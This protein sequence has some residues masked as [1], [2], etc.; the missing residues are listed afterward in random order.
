MGN[1]IRKGVPDGGKAPCV[2]GFE[3][4]RFTLW[5]PAAEECPLAVRS[6]MSGNGMVVV[7]TSVA[8]RKLKSLP[9]QLCGLVCR[10]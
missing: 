7:E 8:D 9:F 3:V 6:E 10:A 4:I 1:V 5:A 2:G